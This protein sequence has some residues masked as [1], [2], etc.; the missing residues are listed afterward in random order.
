MAPQDPTTDV[1]ITHEIE[2][3]GTRDELWEAVTD[4]ALLAEWL[5]DEVHLDVRPGAAGRVVESDGTARQVLVTSVEAGQRVT[6]LWW[7]ERDG[8]SSVELT[9]EP[10]AAPGT[11]RLR[12]VETV[13][14]GERGTTATAC[15]RRWER[16]TTRLWARVGLVTAR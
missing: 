3:D 11:T 5:A 2:L 9:V 16:A 6:W 14:S 15:A 4:E 7:S 8:L 1:R 12:V 13:A 10:G